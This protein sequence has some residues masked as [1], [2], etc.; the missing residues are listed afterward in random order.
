MQVWPRG[1]ANDDRRR[2]KVLQEMRHKRTFEAVGGAFDLL[3]HDET[4]G[5]V[6]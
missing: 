6:D 5:R 4:A 1:K 3:C 2:R